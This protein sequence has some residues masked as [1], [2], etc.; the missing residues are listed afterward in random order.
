MVM[1]RR[2][3][4]AVLILAASVVGGVACAQG[5]PARA[6]RIVVPSSAG[7]GADLSARLISQP[8]SER[9]GQQVVVGNR[10]GAATLIGT[11][12]V[13]KS[14]PDGYTLLLGVGTLATAPA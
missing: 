1:R 5:Y 8:L 4:V 14:P 12:M 10:A 3:A 13:A 7:S 6:L 9:L 11:E 2:A